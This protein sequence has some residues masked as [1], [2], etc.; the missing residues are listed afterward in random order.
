MF[1]IKQED[2]MT[3]RA[4]LIGAYI[5]PAKKAEA[6]SLLEELAR[7]GTASGIGS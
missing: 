2:K 4:L 5:D 1:G 6:Q 3:E 7:L